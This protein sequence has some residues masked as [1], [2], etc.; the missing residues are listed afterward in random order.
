M[1]LRTVGDAGPYKLGR[2]YRIIPLYKRKLRPDARRPPRG[3]WRRRRRRESAQ[4]TNF[5]KNLSLRRL[6]PPLTR[7]PVSLRLGHARGLKAVQG[8]YSIPSRRYATSRR[9]AK[10]GRNYRKNSYTGESSAPMQA[11]FVQR[12]VSAEPTEDINAKTAKTECD[13]KFRFSLNLYP[14]TFISSL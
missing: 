2:N 11:S 12:E 9:Q 5:I 3:S 13:P 14:F 6:L 1:G 4:I 7:S 8:F 10:H